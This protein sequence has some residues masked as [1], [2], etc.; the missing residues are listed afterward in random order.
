MNESAH[1]TKKWKIY[2]VL[3]SLIAAITLGFSALTGYV[4]YPTTEH[5]K[6]GQEL[7]KL[8]AKAF[9]LDGDFDKVVNSD[10][11][12][13]LTG[14]IEAIYTTRMAIGSAMLSAIISVAIVVA[15]YRYLRRNHITTR[16]IG[17]TVFIDTTA[18]ALVMIPTIYIGE[19]VTGI[20]NDPL[21]MILLII[22]L[23]FA[24]VFSAII[25][26]IIARITEWHYNR[27]HGFIEE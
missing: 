4:S 19:L 7:A 21:T 23:P 25:S 18:T 9:S 10:R 14:S 15:V 22:S 8:D 1:K 26:Y 16:P 5:R 2:I 24:V 12:K 6:V 20:K 17:A 27:S 3:I 11:Y 13:E